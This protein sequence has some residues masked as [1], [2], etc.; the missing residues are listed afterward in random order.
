MYSS[1]KKKLK[2]GWIVRI[3]EIEQIY[4]SK[5]N[6][7]C[8]NQVILLMNTNGNKWQYFAITK[9]CAFWNGITSKHK[10]DFYCLNCLHLLRTEN[11]RDLPDKVYKSR[12]LW[13]CFF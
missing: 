11:K 7:I 2:K 3:H 9:L 6:S 12:I 10:C 4:I 5:C 8:E 1:V 13:S